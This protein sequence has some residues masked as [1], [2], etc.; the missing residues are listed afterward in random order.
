[1]SVNVSKVPDEPIIVAAYEA[2]ISIRED[3]PEMFRSLSSVM[4]AAAEE[5]VLYVISNTT[6]AEPLRFGDMVF[7]LSE[8]RMMTRVRGGHQ[9]IHLIL[10]GSDSFMDLAAKSMS[11]PEYGGFRIQIY[12]TLDEAL[13]AARMDMAEQAIQSLIAA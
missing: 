4:L 5:E 12:G 3:I 10:V 9:E 8:V 11:Q 1:M 7:I 6:S 13:A 2:P